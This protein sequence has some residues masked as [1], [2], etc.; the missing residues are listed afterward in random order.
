MMELWAKKR[1]VDGR[2]YPY[3]FI[4]EFTDVDYCYTAI[5]KLD[6]D[7]YKECMIVQGDRCL[8]YVEFDEKRKVR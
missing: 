1:P 3:E 6:R 8:M 7:I 4:L 2:G 5:D